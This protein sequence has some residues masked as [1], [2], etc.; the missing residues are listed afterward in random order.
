MATELRVRRILP[1][2]GALLRDLRLRSLGDAPY[3]FGETVA[4]ARARPDAE[5]RLIARRAATGDAQAWFVA[6]RPDGPVGV[7]RGRRRRPTTLLLFSMWVDPIARRSGVGQQLIAGLEGWAW[8]WGADQTVLWVMHGNDGALAFYRQLGFE[9]VPSGE[10]A[11]SGAEHGA[12]A[13]AREITP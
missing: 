4:E 7:V 9:V 10:D 12:L 5:W 8:T 11:E 6:E 2:E 13:L 3:A 1:S